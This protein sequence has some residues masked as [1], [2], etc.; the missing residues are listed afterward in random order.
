M[1]N[2]HKN[3]SSINKSKYR[4]NEQRIICNLMMTNFR[5]MLGNILLKSKLE[6]KS[7]P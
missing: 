7:E 3:I 2:H 5:I 6:H 4:R 1:V